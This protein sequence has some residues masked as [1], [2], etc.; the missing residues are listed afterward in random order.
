MTWIKIDEDNLPEHDDTCFAYCPDPG[1][2]TLITFDETQTDYWLEYYTHYM[3]M[4]FP[5]PPGESEE[6]DWRYFD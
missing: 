5:N 4:E 6:N 1:H 3:L 2:V